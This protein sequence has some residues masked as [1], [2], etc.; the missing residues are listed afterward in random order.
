MAFC[1]G[2]TFFTKFEDCATVIRFPPT[3]EFRAEPWNLPVSAEFYN[4]R[5]HAVDLRYHLID[6]CITPIDESLHCTK[7]D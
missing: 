3:T 6:L 1:G 5:G 2:D 4:F 7:V